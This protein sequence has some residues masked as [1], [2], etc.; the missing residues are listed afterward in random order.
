MPAQYRNAPHVSQETADVVFLK[1]HLVHIH[2]CN[3]VGL[4]VAGRAGGAVMT[5]SR[6]RGVKQVEHVN[7]SVLFMLR[8]ITQFHC[9]AVE[10]PS[11]RMLHT[12]QRVSPA[13][14]SVPQVGQLQTCVR[15]TPG[16]TE[17]VQVRAV[18]QISHARAEEA[19]TNE[20]ALQAHDG[21]GA[22]AG[23]LGATGSTRRGAATGESSS[24]TTGAATADVR[25]VR[26]ISHT[27]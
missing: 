3:A 19:F 21:A 6:G 12:E 8:H 15:G 14:S 9:T 4:I 17:G 10:A 20:Q 1:V 26:H 24:T 22:A 27:A 18:S 16:A 7:R 5:S 11:R 2:G 13:S 23:M 25:E